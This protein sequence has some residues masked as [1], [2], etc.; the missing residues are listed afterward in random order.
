MQ[1]VDYGLLEKP[2]LYIS[3][4]FERNKGFYY[5][6]LSRVRQ[7]NN[8][9]QWIKFFLTGVIATAEKASDTFKKIIELRKEYDNKIR[10][11]GSSAQNGGKLLLGMFS[12]P[13]MNKNEVA[14]KLGVSYNVAARLIKRFL[15]SNMVVE[16]IPSG[17]KKRYYALW[18]YLNLFR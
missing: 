8:L 4:F 15:K 7:T 12:T 1:L 9:K 5:D 3:D 18:E 10:S 16:Y 13:M 2:T 6:S 14:K 11:F 17:T